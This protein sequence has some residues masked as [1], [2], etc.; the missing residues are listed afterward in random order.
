MNSVEYKNYFKLKIYYKSKMKTREDI[1]KKELS[2]YERNKELVPET[3]LRAH[4]NSVDCLS[5][6]P[7]DSSK[8]L[9]G[10]HDHNLILWDLNKM[11]PIKKAQPHRYPFHLPSITQLVKA[12]GA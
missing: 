1:A 12:C 5:F 11:Q 3:K 8:L 7:T 9:S 10:S 6:M 4:I 2:I